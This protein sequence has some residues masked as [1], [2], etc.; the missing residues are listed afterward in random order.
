MVRLIDYDDL[1]ICDMC[2]DY[3]CDFHDKHFYDCE[4]ELEIWAEFNARFKNEE[5]EGDE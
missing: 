4:C 5:D 2:E 3:Y 1:S